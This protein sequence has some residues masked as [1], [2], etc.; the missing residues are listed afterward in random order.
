MCRG[1]ASSRE[2]YT[3]VREEVGEDDPIHV[4]EVMKIFRNRDQRRRDNRSIHHGEQET[5]KRPS[6]ISC[7]D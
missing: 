6:S 2:N 1:I 5:D 7:R 3:N 4:P